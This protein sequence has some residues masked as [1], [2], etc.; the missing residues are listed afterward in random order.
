MTVTTLAGNRYTYNPRTGEI[1]CGDLILPDCAWTFE[2]FKPISSMPNVNSIILGFTEKCNLRCS[3]CCYS[4]IYKNR[5]VHSARSMECSDI[6]SI[7]EFIDNTIKKQDHIKIFFYGGEPLLTYDTVRYAVDKGRQLWGEEVTFTLSTN[8]TT[9]SEDKIEWLIE[10]QIEL[11]ISI[12]GPERFHDRNRK[13]ASGE[14]SF[15]AISDNLLYIRDEH[16][17]YF[18]KVSMIMTV[19]DITLIPQ[20]A[21]AWN[22]NPLLRDLKLNMINSL[23]PNPVKGIVKADYNTV[24]EFYLKL[25]E[26]YME[27]PDWT[28]LK[29]FL[30]YC[31]AFWKERPI[32]EVEKAIKMPTCL[33]QNTKLYIDS[34]LQ[35]G[36]CEKFSDDYRIGSVK[37]GIKWDKATRLISEFYQRKLDHCKNCSIFRQCNI[38]LTSI[39]YDEEQWEILCHNEQVYT[40]VF[41]TLFCEMAERGLLY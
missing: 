32:F 35:I 8:G 33:P 5:R 38:C 23:I 16:P 37:H 40:K 22:S 26:L 28:L 12:D 30:C 19:P 1:S 29:R 10:N 24:K 31:I 17:E 20:M 7:Y 9:L 15:K 3:Y 21:E 27:H 6:D 25:L 39:E 11:A 41:L 4:G 14:G 34:R 2:E 18:K 13:Y 36:V